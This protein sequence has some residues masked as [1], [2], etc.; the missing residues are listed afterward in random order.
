MFS[1]E[2]G[3]VTAVVGAYLDYH[4]LSNKSKALVKQSPPARHR[5]DLELLCLIGEPPFEIEKGE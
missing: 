2:S 4:I 1:R 5:L 3:D